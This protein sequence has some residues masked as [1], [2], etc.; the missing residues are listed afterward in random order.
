VLT[1]IHL[2]CYGRDLTPPVRLYDLLRDIRS[3]HLIDRVR[4]SS[5]EPR[6]LTDDIIDLVSE[7]NCDA[8]RPAGQLRGRVCPHFHIPL[9]SGDDPTLAAMKRPYDAAFFNQL[10]TRLH[11]RLP[12][13]AIGADVLV[14]F[15]GEDERRFENTC[16]L[17]ER[18]PLAYL[19]VFPFSPRKGT[20]AFSYPGR[21]APATLKERGQRVRRLGRRKKKD[22]YRRFIGRRVEVLVESHRDA[23]SGLLKGVTPNYLSVLIDG[24]EHLKN[25]LVEARIDGLV[26]DRRGGIHGICQ[27]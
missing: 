16:R 20:P 7:S 1:G 15:P 25:T 13:A 9:Q 24:G 23:D 10:V 2:G 12:D 3:P 18:L 21:V 17:I 5:V 27:K 19:H 6:E 26:E 8:P 11:E 14:G 4:L 22:F